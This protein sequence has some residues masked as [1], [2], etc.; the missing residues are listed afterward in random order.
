MLGIK[1]A[2]EVSAAVHDRADVT[3]ALA[4]LVN[5]TIVLKKHFPNLLLAELRNHLP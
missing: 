3:G 5:N 4:D 2:L 1:M